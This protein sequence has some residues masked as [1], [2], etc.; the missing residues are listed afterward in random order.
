[1]VLGFGRGHRVKKIR[2]HDRVMLAASV[3]RDA[4]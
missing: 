4:G 2:L 1:M 3:L